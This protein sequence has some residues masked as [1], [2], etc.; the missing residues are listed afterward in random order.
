[1]T[2]FDRTHRQR[3]ENYIK[4]LEQEVLKLRKEE[5]DRQVERQKTKHSDAYVKALED[6]VAQLQRERALN[7]Q[8]NDLQF[9]AA[10]LTL[11]DQDGN[12]ALR[13][14]M[15]QFPS[16]QASSELSSP[17]YGSDMSCFNP[18]YSSAWQNLLLINP[19]ASHQT[20]IDFVLSYAPLPSLKPS[21]SLTHS[22][23]RRSLH[24][25]S[26]PPHD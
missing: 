3:T 19:L 6:Q 13:A 17:G 15:P 1:L 20:A 16:F 26:P 14:E 9:G 18:Q 22:Q 21:K 23:N 11:L 10:T 25:T 8:D 5:A 2:P 7:P 4:A 24:D 12:W